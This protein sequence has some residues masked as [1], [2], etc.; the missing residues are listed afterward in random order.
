M[1]LQCIALH[2]KQNNTQ[3]ED[4]D[5]AAI[6]QELDE[7]GICSAFF[8]YF[9]GCYCCDVNDQTHPETH[10]YRTQEADHVDPKRHRKEEDGHRTRTGDN[11]RSEDDAQIGAGGVARMAPTA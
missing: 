6:L 8:A 9:D 10:E 3:K 7:F 2:Q 5:Q 1:I 4:K 11:A